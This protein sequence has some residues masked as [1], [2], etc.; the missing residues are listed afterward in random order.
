MAIIIAI[1]LVSSMS[2]SIIPMTT[3]YNSTTQA[4]ITAGMTWD[5]K[6]PNG[7]DRDASAIRLLMWN[8]YQDKVPT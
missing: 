5:L 1:I 3:A 8:R 7:T 4:A 6:Y 2:L